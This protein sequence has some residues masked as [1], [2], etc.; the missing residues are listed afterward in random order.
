MAYEVVDDSPPGVAGFGG[1]RGFGG[2][3]APDAYLATGKP[4]VLGKPIAQSSTGSARALIPP[5]M[6]AIYDACDQSADPVTCWGQNN[7]SKPYLGRPFQAEWRAWAA[8]K[9]AAMAGGGG[10]VV[11]ASQV[12]APAPEPDNTM[13][14]VGIGL[15]AALAL[16]G[17]IYATG[18]KKKR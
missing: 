12:F 15:V 10:G 2:L 3:F 8:Q 5:S 16:G 18:G 7:T 11:P 14:Y 1:F 6:L 13:M 9:A 4:D 17:V